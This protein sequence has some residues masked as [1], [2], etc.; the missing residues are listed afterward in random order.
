MS[1]IRDLYEPIN[2]IIR[3]RIFI[4]S[5]P[6]QNY[7]WSI[8]FRVS[9]YL[10][11]H[12]WFKMILGTIYRYYYF[13]KCFRRMKVESIGNFYDFSKVTSNHL[14]LYVYLIVLLLKYL[15]R[16]Y[17]DKSCF[18]IYKVWLV[19]IFLNV[20][21]WWFPLFFLYKLCILRIKFCTNNRQLELIFI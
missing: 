9:I 18:L 21:N 16:F 19:L 15:I 20:Y 13:L 12:E 7:V 6:I 5:I 2:A 8:V 4:D 14:F 10:L 3:P 1:L 17:W 11:N